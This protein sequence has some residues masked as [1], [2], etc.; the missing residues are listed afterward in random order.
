MHT[1]KE[2]IGYKANYLNHKQLLQL[3]GNFVFFGS[4]FQAINREV[5][6]IISDKGIPIHSCTTNY[7][8]KK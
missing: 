8:I 7:Q 2:N 4:F 3:I 5:W 6:N 1:K